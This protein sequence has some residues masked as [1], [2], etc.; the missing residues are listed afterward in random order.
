MGD[1][2]YDSYANGIRNQVGPEDQTTTKMVFN[3]MASN[4]IQTVTISGL[5]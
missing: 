1:G 3:N 4:D 2:T 5:S